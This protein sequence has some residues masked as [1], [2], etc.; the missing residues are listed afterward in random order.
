MYKYNKIQAIEAASGGIVIG[1]AAAAMV[2]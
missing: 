1:S 2:N